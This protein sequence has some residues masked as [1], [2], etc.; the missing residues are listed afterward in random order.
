MDAV[1]GIGR[2][3]PAGDK[4]DARAPGHFADC[5]GHHGGAALLPA[6]G[7]GEIAVVERI[8]HREVTLTRHAEYVAHAVNA[9]LIDQNLGGSPHVVLGAHGRLLR[10]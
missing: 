8:E 3:R 1:G 10:G 9:Q 6:D 4:A 7:D 5:L 2:A